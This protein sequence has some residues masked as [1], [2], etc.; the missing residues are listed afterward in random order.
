MADVTPRPIASCI[1]PTANRGP[2]VSF[3][4]EL[5]AAQEGVDAEL[6]VVDSGAEPVRALC[7]GTDRVTYVSARR[8]ATIGEKRNLACAYARGEIIV[9][10]DDDD[11]SAPSRLRKQVEPILAGRADATAFENRYTLSL[12]DGAFWTIAPELHRRMYVGDVTGGTMAYRRSYFERGARYPHVSLAEDAALLVELLRAGARLERL[13]N[14]G[15]YVYVR[16]DMSTWRFVAGG[17]L[18]AGGW[19]RVEAPAT[20]PVEAPLRLRDAASRA[21]A[22]WRR[23]DPPVDCLGN[24]EMYLPAAPEQVD[25]CIAFVATE[26]H[27][28]MLDGALTS[29]A[30]FGE[31]PDVPR[32]VFVDEGSPA[33]EAIAARHGASV[34]RC[35]RF[36][37]PPS[38]I[39]GVLYSMARVVRA[40]QYLCL[41]ADVLILDSLAPLFE[42]HARSGYGKVLVASEGGPHSGQTL[43]EGLASVYRATPVEIRRLIGR[44]LR[45]GAEP[46]VLN[47]GVFVADQA[48]LASA[49]AVLRSEPFVRAWVNARPDLGWRTKAA[50]NLALARLGAIVPLCTEYNA[51]IHL[52][53]A[54]GHREEGRLRA[55]WRGEPAR[56]LHFNG[57]GRESYEGWRAQVLGV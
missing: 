47:D 40:N 2:F 22:L 9:H 8:G 1:M 29:L 28:G 52:A 6:V 12:A 7:E 54:I 56:V 44:H 49:D 37:G 18:D 39:K 48:A 50:F 41:D 20:M 51:Q 17:Y 23:E 5:F 16:H 35:R 32:F 43:R 13:A 10:W 45:A 30:L 25:R 14:A 11:W 27:A 57:R 15:E 53:P 21:S 31:V 24:T 38:S 3:A 4:L 36:A 34:L 19:S 33:C 55:E 46:H 42:Q 26:S